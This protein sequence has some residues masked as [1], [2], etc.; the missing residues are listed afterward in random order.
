MLPLKPTGLRVMEIKS[1]HEP[2]SGTWTHLLIDPVS[3]RAAVIDPV[4]AYDTVSG[5]TDSG[6]IDS[7]VEAAEQL[8]C[9]IDW[10]L[11]THAHADHL[12]AADLLRQRSG[13]RIACGHGI[14]QVQ[15]TFSAVFNMSDVATD[16]SQFD[17]LLTEGDT[18]DLGGLVI[19]VIETPGHTAD[20]V[21]YLVEDAIFV[22]DTLFAPAYGTARCDFPGGD[23]AQLYDSIARIHALP[24][25]TRIFLCHDYPKAEQ[26]PVSTVTVAE[27]RSGNIHVGGAT[28]KDDFV[29]M[30]RNRDAQLGLPRLILPSLQVNILA[31]AAPAPDSNGVTYLRTPFNRPLES[32][33]GKKSG[34]ERAGQ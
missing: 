9:S 25:T 24:D 20:G 21:S 18:I 30:R 15:E 5:L 16:G 7:V 22:G 1:F 17:R 31:G 19:R 34:P 23:A 32:L 2:E 29:A 13:A 26:E 6:F 8:N 11:E 4:L 3:R 10:V 33:V 27:S 28:S 14:R 12:T